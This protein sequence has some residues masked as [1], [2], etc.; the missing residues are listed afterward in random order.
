MAIK[1]YPEMVQ[2]TE[3]WFA[4]RCGLL[5]AS[6][7][8]DIVSKKTDRKT[9]IVGYHPREDYD[10]C[11]HLWE[12]L[13]QR[14]TRHVEPQY[15]S[16]DMLR[17]KADEIYMRDLYAKK[18]A[19]VAQV[20]FITNNKWGFTLGYSPDGL[21][22]DNGQIEGK[23]RKQAFQMSTIV[24]QEMPTDFLIQVQ[25]GLLVSERKWCDFI[26]YCGGLPM[27][28]KRIYPN[29]AL[30]GVILMAAQ[31][32]EDR[33]AVATAKYHALMVEQGARLIPTE[34]KEEREIVI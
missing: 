25:T 23:S 11:P 1:I 33:M 12:L 7:M 32:F 8:K 5:T 29:A 18:Y 19:P 17:G 34:R 26:T 9:G 27:Y 13:G 24:G 30:Q 20:G 6:D 15:V 31:M 21:I 16:D 22:A 3:E 14:I 10:D 28:T 4:A 2:G